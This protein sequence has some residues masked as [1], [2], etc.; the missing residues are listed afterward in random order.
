MSE[1][2]DEIEPVTL[3]LTYFVLL[4]FVMAW[5]SLFPSV[6]FGYW[7]FITFPFSFNP[8]YL[9]S[10]IP[11]FFALYGIALLS[12]LIFTKLGIWII[13]KR[14]TYPEV[15]TYRVSMDEPQT[16]A[17]MIKINIRSFGRWLYYFFHLKFLRAFW[18]R[19]QGVKI[20]KNVKLAKYIEDEE[21]QEFGDNTYMAKSVGFSGH[22]MDNEYL[23][24]TET[25]VGKNCIFEHLSGGV[26]ATIGDNSVFRE[27]TGAMKG[28]VC[29]GN[30]IYQGIPCKKIGEYSD[31]SPAEIEEV[32]QKIREKDKTNY[33]KRK[34]APIKISGAKLFTMKLLIVIG[35]CLFALLFLYL[36]SILFQA[37]YSPTNHLLNIAFLT[38]V[39]F[40]FIITLGFFSVG[41]TLFTKIFLAY[42]DHK[43]EI[44]EGYYE[45]DDPR[46]KI[47]K[48]KYLLRLFGLRLFR[49]MPFKVGD[50]F[51]MRFWGNVTFG[52]YIVIENAIVDPQY[53]E[54]GDNVVMAAGARIH[55]HDIIKGKL[56]IKKVKIGKNSIL[57]GCC[58]IKPGVELPARSIVAAAAW[59][60]KN[61]KCKRPALWMGKPA[62]ELPLIA[63]TGSTGIKKKVVDDKYDKAQAQREIKK[64][65]I[66]I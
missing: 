64:K 34:N 37:F 59:F 35:G 55:T 52:N 10:L 65:K 20:G 63:L 27:L 8:I 24:V 21:F 38:L 50:T 26:G 11:L 54:L 19:Q 46:A 5:V 6:L 28:Y 39:P 62:F 29:R 57:G 44:P 4:F 14:I 40:I 66:K 41:T 23:V 9:L 36:Y 43:A 42:Y 49:A 48:I 7:F 16:R 2:T 18:M 25:I 17:F 22:M 31:L 30:A 33:I 15:G 56:Y 53:L 1:K 12:S 51:V 61:R 45:L 13:H 58:H 60:R 32:K 47:F 3:S